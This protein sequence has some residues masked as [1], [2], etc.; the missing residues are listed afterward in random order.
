MFQVTAAAVIAP[1]LGLQTRTVTVFVA[2][3]QPFAHGGAIEEL[4][5]DECMGVAVCP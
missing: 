4:N 5:L 3:L 2:S 1:P